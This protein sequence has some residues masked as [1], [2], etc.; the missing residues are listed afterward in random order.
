[1]KKIAIL[2]EKLFDEREVIYPYYRFIE[3]G[4]QVD[5]IGTE[6]NTDYSSKTGY[7]ETSTYSSAKISSKDYDAVFIPGGFSPDYMRR[8][9]A[10]IDF[11]KAMDKEKKLIA[12]ICHGPWMLASCCDIQGK[13]IT[14]FSSLKDDLINAGGKYLDE[15]V[16]Q[17]GHII[18]SRS[19]QDL[20]ALSKAII[21]YLDSGDIKA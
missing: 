13:K 6:A 12:A 20:P 10:T 5:F 2:L 14:S 1:M 17:D 11:V 7:T 3:E 8:C 4:Y 9:K 18:T 15:A 21:K 19:P 16:V